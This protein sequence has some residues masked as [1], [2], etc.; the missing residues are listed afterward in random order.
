MEATK[1]KAKGESVEED[2]KDLL[3]LLA[4]S[5]TERTICRLSHGARLRIQIME[6]GV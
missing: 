5:D 2:V 4:D 6:S 1:A 3:Q